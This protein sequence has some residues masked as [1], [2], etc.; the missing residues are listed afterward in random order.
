VP[1]APGHEANRR[2]YPGIAIRAIQ[3][4]RCET[5]EVLVVPDP[6][7]VTDAYLVE[8]TSGEDRSRKHLPRCLA[9]E[10]KETW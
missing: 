8:A 1:V 3:E 9:D 6:F 4:D 5:S 10:V 7:D 2:I